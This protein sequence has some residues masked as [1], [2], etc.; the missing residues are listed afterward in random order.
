VEFLLVFLRAKVDNKKKVY[1]NYEKVKNI[2][3]CCLAPTQSRG[4][5]ATMEELW[6]LQKKKKLSKERG[7]KE[8]REVFWGKEKDVCI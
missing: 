8:A 1:K 6:K 4:S 5:F 2:T 7:Y 3:Y